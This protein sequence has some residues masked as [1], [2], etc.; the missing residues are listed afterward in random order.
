ML[1]TGL[2]NPLDEAIAAAKADSADL[3]GYSKIDE[4]PY[5][6]VRK[7][8]TVIVRSADAEQQDLMICKGAVQNVIAAC[9]DVWSASGKQQLND[10]LRQKIDGRFRAWSSQGYRVLALAVRHFDKQPSY[11][12]SDEAGLAFAGFLLF[13]DPPKAGIAET[14]KALAG[15]G[16]GVKVI[17]GD[18]R[19]VAQH[20]ASAVG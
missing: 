14:L 7:S 3:S 15:R 1:Q 16:V 18:N 9:S 11:G 5:D 17:T 12:R 20:L 8:L 6:F 19:Y 10:A 2:K 4:I 13:L